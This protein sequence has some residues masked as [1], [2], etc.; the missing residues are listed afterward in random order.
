M[1]INVIS[2]NES[3][4]QISSTIKWLQQRLV[5]LVSR[6][7]LCHPIVLSCSQELDKHIYE[8]QKK[9]AE[10]GGEKMKEMGN[11]SYKVVNETVKIPYNEREV[12]YVVGENRLNESN[13]R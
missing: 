8:Y 2:S 5:I 9:N 13:I 7:G 6:Y 12:E 11:F 4:N 3:I 1:S 10:K